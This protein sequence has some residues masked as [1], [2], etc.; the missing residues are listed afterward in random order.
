MDPKAIVRTG[1][2]K[3]S[4]AY[5]LTLTTRI[6]PTQCLAWLAPLLAP[7]HACSTWAAAAACRDAGT[8]PLPCRHRRRPFARAD[9]AGA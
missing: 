5:P 4:H 9:R 6:R 2:D 3:V 7:A 1:Y 8:R